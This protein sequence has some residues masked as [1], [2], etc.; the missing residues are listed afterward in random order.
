MSS[1]V[2]LAQD[3]VRIPSRGGID[4]YTPLVERLEAW[5]TSHGLSPARLL[6]DGKLVGVTAEIDGARPGPTYVLDATVDTAPFG[7]R[8]RWTRG[9]VSGEIE[10]GWLYGRGAA[11]SKAGV[12]IFAHLGARLAAAKEDLAGRVI[13]LFEGDEHSGSF[14]GAVTFF[15]RTMAH[16]KIDAIMIGYPGSERIVIGG[17]GFV[18]FKLSVHGE[19]A[20]S[21]SSHPT[22]SNAVVKAGVLITAL[23]ALDDRV[24]DRMA[25][26]FDM[27]PK[28]TVTSVT[29]G[30]DFSIVPDLCRIDVDVRLTPAFGGDEAEA[31]IHQLVDR[32]D[33][34]DPERPTAV[35][36]IPGW[37][38]FHTPDSAPFVVALQRAAEATLARSVPLRV[39]GPSNIGNYAASL[40]IPAVAGFGAAYRN[41]HAADECIEV[42]SI[43][44]IYRAYSDAMF[45][46]LIASDGRPAAFSSGLEGR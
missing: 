17:R 2:E 22:V 28:I 29:G 24:V 1:I 34:K 46:L 19:A 5:L 45:D 37:P 43:E 23:A 38:P 20:H 11:D 8:D 30:E 9:P 12:A 26:G 35:E 31:A 3:L 13:L 6:A 42:A 16:R 18:R 44:P 15:E 7:D 33:R 36:T 41:L 40:G 27:P 4:D 32:L 25:A 14:A 39:A 21:G 10:D